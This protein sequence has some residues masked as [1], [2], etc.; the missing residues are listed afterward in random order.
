MSQFD[1]PAMGDF[2]GIDPAVVNVSL[3][4][5]PTYQHRGLFIQRAPGGMTRV[6]AVFSMMAEEGITEDASV[7]YARSDVLGRI[8]QFLTFTSA[9]NKT[10]PFTWV[11]ICQGV[12]ESPGQP[13]AGGGPFGDV[14]V[15]ARWL[16]FLK[17]PFRGNAG[18]SHAPPPLLLTIGRLLAA[19]V[20]MTDC[21]IR[22]MAPF[23]PA[24]HYPMMAE[25]Q[26]TMTVTRSLSFEPGPSP[27]VDA[28]SRF[29]TIPAG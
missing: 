22:W 5:D 21:T 4:V 25:V 17:F 19:R 6:S 28:I 8:E 27:D 11:F 9:D 3:Q 7:N 20:V 23:E 12:G 14:V 29:V 24:T 26:C 13:G 18:L 1:G 16:E 10:I 15:P 2:P